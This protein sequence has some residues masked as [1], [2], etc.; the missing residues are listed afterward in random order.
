MQDKANFDDFKISEEDAKKIIRLGL[1]GELEFEVMNNQ[2]SSYQVLDERQL[3]EVYSNHPTRKKIRLKDGSYNSKTH[4]YESIRYEQSINYK[5]LWFDAD[6]F[7]ALLEEHSLTLSLNS[8]ITLS[9]EAKLK[10]SPYWN[11]LK[12]LTIQAMQLYPE[13]SKTQRRIKITEN[14][15]DW[16]KGLGANTREADIIKKTLSDF[17]E[18]LN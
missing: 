4:R 11:S 16:L 3:N 13:W 1:K 6:K 10:E 17:Y 7:K 12:R 2:Q 8:V 15:I 14:L 18:E 9:P 5:D